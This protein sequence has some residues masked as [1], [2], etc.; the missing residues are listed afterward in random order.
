MIIFCKF[1]YKNYII[2]QKKIKTQNNNNLIN[3]I[4]IFQMEN[5]Y[6]LSDLN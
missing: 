5:S 6:F 4:Q 3:I 2:F 1:K